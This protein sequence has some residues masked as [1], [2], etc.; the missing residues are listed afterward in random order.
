V[1]DGVDFIGD[2]V[3]ALACSRYGEAFV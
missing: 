3:S 1:H 2:L